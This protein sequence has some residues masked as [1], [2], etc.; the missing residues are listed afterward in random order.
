MR[1]R[2][3]R[4]VQLSQSAYTTTI[5]Q[6]SD[7]RSVRHDTPMAV[8]ELQPHV[9]DTS[10]LSLELGGGSDL[11][12]AS[13]ASTARAPKDTQSSCSED[14]DSSTGPPTNSLHTNFYDN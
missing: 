11:V 5:S 9:D 8:A 6:L 10:S 12:V 2:S 7:K 14:S 13:D 3:D 4:K 1:D